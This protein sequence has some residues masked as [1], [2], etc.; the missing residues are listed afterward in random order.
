MTN[1]TDLILR[2]KAARKE[3]R[4]SYS[5]ILSLMEK[6]GDYVSRSTLSRVFADGSEFKSFRYEHTIF[7]IAN[8]LS[9][10]ASMDDS[11]SIPCVEQ[12][13]AFLERQVVYKED[14]MDKLLETVF[15][16]DEQLQKL[17]E[18]LLDS[19]YHKQTSERS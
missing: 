10:D 13:V 15:H 11:K 2:I 7:P 14:K 3:K 9:V 17:V 6:N 16:K 19:P 5:D 18:L 1:T 8:A 12:Y 4:L